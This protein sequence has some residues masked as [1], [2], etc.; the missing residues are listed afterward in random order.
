VIDL[1]IILSRSIR[2]HAFLKGHFQRQHVYVIRKAY[3]VTDAGVSAKSSVCLEDSL[4][5]GATT[6]QP[7]CLNASVSREKQIYSMICIE[8]FEGVQSLTLPSLSAYPVVR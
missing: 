1:C 6:K 5:L 7:R 8:K 2:P 3:A 4:E